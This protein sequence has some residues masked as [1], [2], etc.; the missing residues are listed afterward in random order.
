M[1]I[2]QQPPREQ[3]FLASEYID[4]AIIAINRA[5]VLTVLPDGTS[6]LDNYCKK[7]T[8]EEQVLNKTSS[9]DNERSPIGNNFIMDLHIELIQ[10]QHRIAIKLLNGTEG[11]V[12]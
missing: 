3:L 10:A 1:D 5:H 12:K 8:A 7:M 2:F 6:V 4:R 9:S 11:K